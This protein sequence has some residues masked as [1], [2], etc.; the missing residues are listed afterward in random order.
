LDK[1][2]SLFHGFNPLPEATGF[3]SSFGA[4]LLIFVGDRKQNDIKSDF[5]QQS[6]K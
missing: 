3:T 2:F 5:E 6:G 4:L 1:I